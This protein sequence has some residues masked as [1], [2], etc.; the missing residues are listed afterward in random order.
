[1]ITVWGHVEQVR[2]GSVAK[3]TKHVSPSLLTSYQPEDI[4][5]TIACDIQNL[6]RGKRF[7]RCCDDVRSQPDVGQVH[8]QP[9]IAIRWFSGER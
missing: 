6:S 7:I 5:I 1:M 3:E 4:P 2:T 8:A 9:C